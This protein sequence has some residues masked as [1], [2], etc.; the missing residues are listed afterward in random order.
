MAWMRIMANRVTGKAAHTAMPLVTRRSR[1]LPRH[2]PA[3]RPRTPPSSTRA[4]VANSAMASVCLAPAST[5]A[6]MS[7]PTGSLPQGN[8][9]EGAKGGDWICSPTYMMPWVS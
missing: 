9:A 3:S 8:C 4:S 2:Q 1:R 5:R 6:W 7:R